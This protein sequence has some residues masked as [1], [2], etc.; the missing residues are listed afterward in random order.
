MKAKTQDSSP[1]ATAVSSPS[2]EVATPTTA[3]VGS[4]S[5]EVAVSSAVVGG[6]K[7][8]KPWWT[9]YRDEDVVAFDT[10]QVTKPKYSN[11]KKYT[12]HVGTVD[13]VNHRLETIYSAKVH[14]PPDS[15]KDH[16]IFQ[17]L[18]GFNANS[19]ADPQLPSE[20]K[21]KKDVA[22]ILKGKLV[23]TIGG[24]SDFRA[25]GLEMADFK[26]FEL[27]SHFFVE[28]RNE[29]DVEIREGHSLR[30]LA[31][32]YLEKTQEQQHSSLED[33]KLTMQL[34]HVYKNVKFQDDPE[35][36]SNS[37]NKHN[38]YNFIPIIPNPIKRMKKSN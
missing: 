29:H 15:F 16:R 11:N 33:A 22:E 1:N 9:E 25:L 12:Q 28:K 19:F 37:F 5:S 24:E 38:P 6:V 17:L 10:E 32:Y 26:Y 2:S 20:D 18:T 23:I 3:A 21:V 14:H 27:Q 36:L 31:S 4:S 13:I 34:F 8:S 30:S 7:D 35:N